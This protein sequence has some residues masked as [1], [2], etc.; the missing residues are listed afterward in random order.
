MKLEEEIKQR[1][2]KTDYQKL[3]V[4]ILFTHGWLMTHH[5]NFFD[6]VFIQYIVF[7][8]IIEKHSELFHPEPVNLMVLRLL[9]D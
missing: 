4:N 6:N 2:F 8:K 1:K 3:A 9:L 7:H 5:K